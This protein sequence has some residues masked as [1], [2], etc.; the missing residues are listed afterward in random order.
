[1]LLS[2]CLKEDEILGESSLFHGFAQA[3]MSADA[4]LKYFEL[5]QDD[6]NVL[7]VLIPLTWSL[8]GNTSFHVKMASEGLVYCIRDRFIFL[9][10][11]VIKLLSRKNGD[12][13]YEIQE[14]AFL[15]LCVL[16]RFKPSPEVCYFI[17]AFESRYGLVSDDEGIVDSKP[18][19]HYQVLLSL[20]Q[21]VRDNPSLLTSLGRA[22][23]YRCRNLTPHIR[24]EMHVESVVDEEQMLD[25]FDT[26][27]FPQILKVVTDLSEQYKCNENINK[28][29]NSL[30]EG[31]TVSQK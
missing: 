15:L 29:L 19:S 23:W 5:F 1:M 14:Q 12:V 27:F 9:R 11:I 20:L 17:Q 18:T 10:A 25:P 8:M 30:T 24:T 26:R 31:L 22:L 21:R 6:L 16:N 2:P 7:K 28:I 3:T 4:I 13:D